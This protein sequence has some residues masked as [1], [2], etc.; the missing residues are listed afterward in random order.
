MLESEDYAYRAGYGRLPNFGLMELWRDCCDG[1]ALTWGGRTWSLM[2]LE[3][4]RR[5]AAQQGT[6]FKWRSGSC[7]AG[8]V[9]THSGMDLYKVRKG[10]R[11]SEYQEDQS[12]HQKGSY[13]LRSR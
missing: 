4:A 6:D 7:I 2:Q 11:G 13:M 12:C 5:N 8:Q 1:V 10:S 9:I 3:H